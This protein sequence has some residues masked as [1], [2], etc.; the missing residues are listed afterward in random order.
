MAYAAEY[1][2]DA[3]YVMDDLGG[4]EGEKLTVSE[5]VAA[6]AQMTVHDLYL[7]KLYAEK[8]GSKLP[9]T[10]LPSL[11][12]IISRQMHG[13]LA[14]M[15]QRLSA[16]LPEAFPLLCVAKNETSFDIMCRKLCRNFLRKSRLR[17][18]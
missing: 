17:Q 5:D 18:I 10:L 3:R 15:R 12:A 16:T 6:V 9:P 8:D 13:T 7:V 14:E 4:C 11:C 2:L 1:G